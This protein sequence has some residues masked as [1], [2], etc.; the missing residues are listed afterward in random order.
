LPGFFTTRPGWSVFLYFP[1]SVSFPLFPPPPCSV[2][3]V[4]STGDKNLPFG[5]GGPPCFFRQLGMLRAVFF[6]FEG[7]FS[8]PPSTCP[9]IFLHLSF[10]TPDSFTHPGSHLSLGHTYPFSSQPHL[11]CRVLQKSLV[12]LPQPFTQSTKT[13][14]CLF[15]TL[16][17]RPFMTKVYKPYSG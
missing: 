4:L 16:V 6:S 3:V 14:L 7:L 11:E 2:V 17:P 5:L 10:H 12:C 8:P 1:N 9:K 13:L 15:P